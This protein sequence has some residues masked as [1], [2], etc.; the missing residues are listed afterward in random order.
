MLPL[1]ANPVAPSRPL[2]IQGAAPVVV[3]GT[4]GPVYTPAPAPAF[5]RPLPPPVPA[6]Q[7]GDTATMRPD[8]AIVLSFG[9]VSA[10]R[11]GTL[12]PRRAAD[13]PEL[14]G[15]ADTAGRHRAGPDQA[16][17]AVEAVLPSFETPRLTLRPR[18]MADLPDCLAM[19]RDPE[20][21][22]YIDGTLV[23][24]GGASRLFVEARITAAYPA[25]LGY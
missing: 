4:P 14:S 13:R 20:V 2:V 25:G 12:A 19:D 17:A 3:M 7:G 9:P 15:A 16:A 10:A 5:A 22:R 6:P 1:P 18:T 24:P 21:V 8:A 23:R 11:A